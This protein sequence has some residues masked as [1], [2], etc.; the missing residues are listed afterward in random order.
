MQQCQIC[1]K[2]QANVHLKQVLDGETLELFLCEDCAEKG[3]L[4]VDPGLG[5]AEF[6]LGLTSA[7]D[8]K[9]KRRREEDISCPSCHMRR[10]DFKKTSR[11][12]CPGCY[13]AFAA[14]LAP[15]LA[16]MHRG[17]VHV[18]KSPRGAP[19]REDI[20]ALRKALAAAVAA[21]NFEEAARLRDLIRAATAG[22]AEA[23][24]V[25]K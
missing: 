7:K 14:D 5:M 15:M 17:V 16:E 19:C 8:N 12:G 4:R 25:S 20:G 10:A 1:G 11:L 6:V 21:Q 13:D 3:G 9:E 24:A 23:G 18:G 22:G 2:K